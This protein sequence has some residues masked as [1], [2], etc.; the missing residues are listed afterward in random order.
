MA[1]AASRAADAFRAALGG[2]PTSFWALAALA[3]LALALVAWRAWGMCRRGRERFEAP[4]TIFVSVA[5]YRDSDCMQTVSEAFAKA[6]HPDR[7]FVGIC[8]QNSPDGEEVCLRPDFQH[9]ARVRRISLPH[10]EA[11]GPTYARY[12]CATLYRN[13]TYFMQIDS[14]TRFGQD[15]DARVVADLRRCPSAKP[16]LTHYPPSWEEMGKPASEI[17]VPRLCTANF[18]QGN[19]L[20]M[21][22]AVTLP[23]TEVPREVPFVAGGFLFGPGSMAREVPFDPDLPMLFQGEEILHAARL[24]T[25]GYDLFTPTDN[26]VYH[27]YL[28]EA[29][30]KFWDDV[31]YGAQQERT[32]A[33]VRQLLTGGQRD[34]SHGMG[35]ARTLEEYMRFAGLDMEA[36]TSSGTFCDP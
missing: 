8:E 31:S 9:H 29:K 34:Y 10:G 16:V 18:E 17:G 36:K 6:A 22:E 19:G 13:E 21:L 26:F 23:P 1:S 12:L 2:A 7:I 27:Y 32:H 5:S 33:K 14:H 11:L 20:P 24:W 30:P 28:R 4:E 35:K 25:H 15:W 3:A